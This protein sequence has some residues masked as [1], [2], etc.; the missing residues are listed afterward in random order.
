MYVCMYVC[1]YVYVERRFSRGKCGT[2]SDNDVCVG[3]I[4]PVGPG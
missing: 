4:D 3:V 1:M 2:T